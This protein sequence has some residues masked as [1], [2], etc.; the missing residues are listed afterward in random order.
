MGER[1]EA[2][3][4][5][6]GTRGGER[7][8]GG[9]GG[10]RG[11]MIGAGKP[12]E[13]E[14]ERETRGEAEPLGEARGMAGGAVFTAEAGHVE[15]GRGLGRRGDGDACEVERGGKLGGAAS[16]VGV[17]RE[18]GVEEGSDGGGEFA[19]GAIE[20]QRFE[21]FRFHGGGKG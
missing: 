8:G 12:T 17:L 18:V 11:A 6:G 4:G 7:D 19:K 1:P 3:G 15:R 16:V 20:Q 10:R 14:A 21:K 2:G 9:A 5:L 13:T